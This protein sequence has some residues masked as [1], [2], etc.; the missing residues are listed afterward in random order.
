[1]TNRSTRLASGA[2][3]A[4]AAC[5]LLAAA[6]ATAAT[7]AGATDAN[8]EAEAAALKTCEQN[9]CAV[10][11]KKAATGDVKCELKKTWTKA[12]ITKSVEKKH[13]SWAFAD[14]RCT[15]PLIIPGPSLADALTK[16]AHT[17]E[18]PVHTAHCEV[19]SAKEGET[20]A[21][22]NVDL[23]P[24]FEFKDGKAVKVKLNI[25]KIEAPT[26][27]KG[28]IWTAAKAED[29]FGLFEG[30]MLTALNKLLNES[31]PKHFP[32]Q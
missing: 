14:A 1:M 7:A 28:A 10:A 16:P 25:G 30:Q 27:V 5:A 17:L 22:V 9:L 19:D 24:K 8:K 32:A 29:Y 18:L 20:A 6:S 4:V 31:C 21:S 23:A 26:A 12:D 3:A 11:V 15:V 13:L 2:R